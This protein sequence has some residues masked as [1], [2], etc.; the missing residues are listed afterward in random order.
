LIHRAT[1]NG[2]VKRLVLF[3]IAPLLALGWLLTALPDGPTGVRAE[4]TPN[5]PALAQP[6]PTP[7]SALG[8]ISGSTPTPVVSVAPVVIATPVPVVIRQ[9]TA[10]PL[11]PVCGLGAEYR[12]AGDQTIVLS[13][14]A[15]D[16]PQGDFLVATITRPNAVSVQVCYAP[17]SSVLTLS[18]TSGSEVTRSARSGPAH[19][20][21]DAIVASV[22]PPFDITR[23]VR[24]PTLREAP[25]PGSEP[26]SVPPLTG[27]STGGL[28]IRPPSTGEA[29]LTP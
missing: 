10:T 17:D 19:A 16:L 23:G 1:Y 21:F 15:M 29:G 8:G 12:Q 6:S 18:E 20:A 25:A 4:V 7:F 27:A 26:P 14:F 24:V 28:T 11:P 5:A 22:R 3:A 13:N 9:P 2:W